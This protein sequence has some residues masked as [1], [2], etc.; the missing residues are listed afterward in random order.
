MTCPVTV[1][2]VSV[3][4]SAFWNTKPSGSVF[5]SVGSGAMPPPLVT[6]TVSVS[7]APVARGWSGRPSR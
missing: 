4:V 1:H 7:I 3:S 6:V 2:V 5:F